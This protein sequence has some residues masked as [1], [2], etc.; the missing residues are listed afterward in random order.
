SLFALIIGLSEHKN[1]KF[2][3]INGSMDAMT[4]TEFL[5]SRLRVPV[6]QI[7]TLLDSQATRSRIIQSL[8]DLQCNPN[9]R[10]NDPI[11][12][13]FAGHGLNCQAPEG[14]TDGEILFLV[15]H[16]YEEED[17]TKDSQPIYGIPHRTINALL[18]ELFA[19]KGDNITMILDCCYAAESWSGQP[20]KQGFSSI[21][22]PIPSSLD[23]GIWTSRS[24]GATIPAIFPYH[25]SHM[26]LAA[27][28]F[29]QVAVEKERRGLFT[30]K[31]VHTLCGFIEENLTYYD[32]TSRIGPL[33]RT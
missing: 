10:Y 2:N 26:L 27:G 3:G 22:P 16:D 25:R 24:T 21:H 13:Y 23:E 15:P 4:V 8:K 18:A 33:S 31:L 6:S 32:I 29:D 12:I 14:W 5:K 20:S 19:I 9:I 1:S 17:E 7:T 28:D 11:L 30:N